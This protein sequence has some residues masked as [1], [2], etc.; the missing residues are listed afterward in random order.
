MSISIEPKGFRLII[1]PIASD[2]HETQKGILVMDLE[3][4]TGEVV[5]VPKE[6]SEEYKKGDII[7]YT[8]NGGI[9]LPHYKKA[10]HIWLNA[11]PLNTEVW[12]IVTKTED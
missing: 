5:E 1:K 11:N 12:G 2:T 10:P 9:S 6:L 3:T 7:I 8:K 4:D